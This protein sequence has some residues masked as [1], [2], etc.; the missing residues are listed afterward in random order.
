MAKKAKKSYNYLILLAIILLAIAFFTI[1]YSIFYVD[2]YL[3]QT[4]SN[5]NILVKEQR[6]VKIDNST[7]VKMKLPAVDASGKGVLTDLAIEVMPGTGRILVDIDN[8]IFWADTQQSIKIA[9]YVAANISEKDVSDYDLVYNIY[10][11][12]SLIGGPSAG[13]AIVIA[14]IA[15]L[16]GKPLNQSVMITGTIN[17]DGSIGRVGDIFE[18]SEAARSVNATLFLVPEGQGYGSVSKTEKECE[19]YGIVEICTIEQV[20]EKTSINQNGIRIIEVSNIRDAL[21]YFIK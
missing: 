12:A 3:N 20:Y 18:K 7:F 4:K 19:K 10:A 5:E 17:Q 6:F 13:A 15:A 16:E 11:N 9:R 8:L 21:E 14:T 1:I 2:K